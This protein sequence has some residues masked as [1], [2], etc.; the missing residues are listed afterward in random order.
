LKKINRSKITSNKHTKL[1]LLLEIVAVTFLVAVSFGIRVI[2]SYDVVFQGDKVNYSSVDDYFY[3]RIADNLLVNW[4]NFTNTDLYR[5]YPGGVVVG[6]TRLLHPFIIATASKVTGINLDTIAAWIPP[7]YGTL[8]II[9]LYV[10]LRSVFKRAIALISLVFLSVM[11]GEF[12]SRSSLGSMDS[13]SLE[14][15]ASS[16]MISFLL[17]SLSV[18]H[19]IFKIILAIIAGIGLSFYVSAWE[20]APVFVLI[21]FVAVFIW[22]ILEYFKKTATELPYL[23]IIIFAV[24]PLITLF[25][26]GYSLIQVFS[27][28]GL[29]GGTCILWALH[30]KPN[31]YLIIAAIIATAVA[32]IGWIVFPTQT[33]TI[34]QYAINFF[35]WN[36]TSATAEEAPLLLMNGEFSFSP[37]WIYFAGVM[38][39]FLVGIGTMAYYVVKKNNKIDW[40]IVL[41]WSIVIFLAMTSMKRWAYYAAIPMSVMAAYICW[42]FCKNIAALETTKGKAFSPG[43]ILILV[44][45]ISMLSIV[46]FLQMVPTYANSVRSG[47]ISP[48][49]REAIEWLKTTP[50]PIENGYT[51]MYSEATYPDTAYGVMTWW[52]YGYWILREGH[53]IT[54]SDPG[55]GNRRFCGWFLSTNN[56]TEAMEAIESMKIKYIIIDYSMTTGKNY[57]IVQHAAER[58]IDFQEPFKIYYDHRTGSYNQMQINY[59]SYYQELMVRLY[60]FNGLAVESPGCPVFRY[61]EINGN[62]EIIEAVDLPDYD[63]A[64]LYVA[65]HREAKYIIGGTNPFLSPIKMD[66]LPQFKPVFFSRS[67]IDM[68]NGMMM[69]EVKIFEVINE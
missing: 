28:A 46:P 4:P 15:V 65:Q 6:N 58:A 7:I 39:L 26:T 64:T 32:I 3:M 44:V 10:A 24:I 20:G 8:A 16:F 36:A 17:L 11:P 38:Y 54:Y 9:L 12:L 52:D 40:I 51:A 35:R 30:K 19:K 57:S 61:E 29:A 49:W 48:G 37:A 41:V 2:P 31:I 69:P 66:A 50:D 56:M 63:S 59:I 21:I 43:T 5:N 22:W 45:L 60:N 25:I 13:H 53:R 33:N 18:K 14:I 55:G 27:L 47:Q 1:K 67:S 68:G 34:L 62:R 23:Q 42:V